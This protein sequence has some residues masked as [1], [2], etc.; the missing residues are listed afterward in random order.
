MREA[1]SG[2]GSCLALA[3]LLGAAMAGCMPPLRE[4]G[5]IGCSYRSVVGPEGRR[6]PAGRELIPVSVR[7]DPIRLSP[8]HRLWRGDV[9]WTA[10]LIP[11]AGLFLPPNQECVNALA[12]RSEAELRNC[13]EDLATLQHGEVQKLLSQEIGKSGL[14]AA[15]GCQESMVGDYVLRGKCDLKFIEHRHYSGLGIFFIGLLP[16]FTC[17][18]STNDMSCAAHFEVVSRD[19]GRTLLSKDYESH[20]HY[21]VWVYNSGRVFR[22]YGREL[23]PQIVTQLI[24][25]LEAIPHDRWHP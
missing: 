15:V 22:A 9:P 3:A 23:F 21:V 1:T 14:F 16:I 10:A 24:E 7:V 8:P 12:I 19:G 4:K 18:T 13:P 25:D 5:L 11:V 20:I 17:P 2:T 6:T